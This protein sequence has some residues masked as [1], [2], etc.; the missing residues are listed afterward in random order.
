M[1]GS[2][3]WGD[4]DNDG[5][6]DILLAGYASSGRVSKVYRNDGGGVFT[7]IGAALTGVYY[8]SAAWGDYDNDGDLD[9]LLA[10]TTGST[11]VATVYRNDGGGAFTDIGAA[12]TGV[13]YG[14]AAW[15]DYDNDGDLDIL[16]VGASASGGGVSKVYRNDGSGVFTDIGASLT[17]I[18]W[19]SA[20]WGDYD[21]DGRLD[22]LL[23]GESTV[24]VRVS[25]VYRSAVS[26]P[27][28]VPGT[29][30]ALVAAVAAGQVTLSWT[31]SSD[32]ETPPSGLTYNVRLG[33]TPGGTRCHPAHGLAGVGLP[34]GRTTRECRPAHDSGVQRPR[35]RDVLLERP[36]R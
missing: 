11:R 5:D 7:D 1:A 4:Y 20:A 17:G 29:P 33:T 3:A 6:L 10:G 12:L 23:A 27:N 30:T 19:S 35:P 15:G 31:A 13:Y 34:P 21:N 16:L 26:A 36:G 22:I 14:S 8:G 28:T 18:Y 32:A 2:V 9:I 24:G 25:Q